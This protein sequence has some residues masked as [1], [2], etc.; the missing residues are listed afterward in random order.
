MASEAGWKSNMQSIAKTKEVSDGAEQQ[1]YGP[2]N[3]LCD[4]CADRENAACYLTGGLRPAQ[5]RATKRKRPAFDFTVGIHPA[6]FGATEQPRSLW[7]L[8]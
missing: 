6:L 7:A 8:F 2:F 1:D 5:C 3:T 4:K